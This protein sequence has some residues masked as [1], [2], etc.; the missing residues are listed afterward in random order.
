MN[1]AARILVLTVAVLLSFS[2]MVM[3]DDAYRLDFGDSLTLT[4]WP[5][6][7]EGLQQCELAVRPDGKVALALSITQLDDYRLGPG[8]NL[9]I[10]VWGLA[11]LSSTVTVR[12]DGKVAFPL[13][14]E[15]TVDGLT[16]AELANILT[17]KLRYYVKEP[18]VTVNVVKPRRLPVMEI[19]QAA[20][21]T[22]DEL[23]QSIRTVLAKYIKNPQLTLVFSQYRTVRVHVLG[24]ATKPGTYEI[25]KSHHVLDAL[26]AA[27]GYTRDA[28]RR[29]VYVVRKST[30]EYIQVDL[31]RLL[32]KGDI[33][34]NYVLY[35][36]DTVFIARNGMS[37]IKDILPII[38]G[39][40]Q[41]N[42]MIKD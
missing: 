24:E 14:G 9:N 6:G 4:F 33:T 21:L 35:E 31:N 23:T 38:S 36:G 28:N 17:E 39:L 29:Q 26:G 41:V 5:D 3:A 1:R 2:T 20:G 13:I 32:K 27:G 11:D 30:G 25:M 15:M 18:I 34:Q 40:Y 19:L 42:E 37:F 7:Y 10:N 12:S 16:P 8:D 22:V